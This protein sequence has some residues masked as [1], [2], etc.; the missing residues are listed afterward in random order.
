MSRF[1]KV[2]KCTMLELSTKS[3]II[4]ELQE[5]KEDGLPEIVIAEMYRNKEDEWAY[6]KGGIRFETTTDN[7][8]YVIKG[9][10]AMFEASKEV[11]KTKKEKAPKVDAKKAVEMM[12]E[13]E[14]AELLKMLLGTA[15]TETPEVKPEASKGKASKKDDADELVLEYKIGNTTKKAGKK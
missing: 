9:I 13:E 11:V 8:N 14:K 4:I 10:K 12:T 7:A 3:S 6:C 1:T 2:A 5:G 15:K